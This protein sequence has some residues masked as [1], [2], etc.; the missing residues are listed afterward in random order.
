VRTLSDQGD[1]PAGDLDEEFALAVRS[2]TLTFTRY[3]G[4]VVTG[5]QQVGPSDGAALGRLHL[6]GPQTPHELATWLNLSTGAVTGM[7]DRLEAAGYAARSPHPTDRRKV[8]VSLTDA[9]RQLIVEDLLAPMTRTLS[10][11]LDPFDPD[12]RRHII[13]ALR[14][15]ETALEDAIGRAGADPA[16]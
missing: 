7:L 4:L 6:C 8:L 14:A 1:T 10:P 15:A 16:G 2:L 9:A 12:T 11:V 5:R 13:E 3:R